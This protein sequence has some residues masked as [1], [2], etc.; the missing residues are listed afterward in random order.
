MSHSSYICVVCAVNPAMK[1]ATLN[2]VPREGGEMSHSSCICVVCAVNSAT[3]LL[4]LTAFL[5][6]IW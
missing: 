2:C 1:A 4:H 3:R 5:R 6:W